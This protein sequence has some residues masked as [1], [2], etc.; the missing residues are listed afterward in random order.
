MAKTKQQKIQAV[1]EGYND[2]KNSETVIIAD[3]TG[4]SVNDLNTFRKSL[5]EIGAGFRVI[6]KRLLNIIF[7]KEELPFEIE[8]FEGQTGVIFSPKDLIETAGVSYG[9]SR[10][11]DSFKILGGFEVKTKKF[12]EGAEVKA[13]GQLPS[14]E[15]LLGQLVG[16]IASP[17]RFFLYVLSEKSKM[18][19]QK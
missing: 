11:K 15:I 18:V 3:F 13:I 9:F 10:I 6:K 7:K 2:L 8:K 5:K 12:I 19:E 1:E 4:V 17:I 16:M 14:R